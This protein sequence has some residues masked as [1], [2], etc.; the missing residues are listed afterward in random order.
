MSVH[1]PAWETADDFD[2]L[3][4]FYDACANAEDTDRENGSAE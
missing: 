4:D 3:D 2:G 1:Y